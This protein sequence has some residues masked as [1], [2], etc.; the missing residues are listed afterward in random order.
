M[1]AGLTFIDTAE[2]YGY[3]MSETFLG[4]A[5]VMPCCCPACPA[6][7][8]CAVIYPAVLPLCC[9]LPCCTVLCCALLRPP[10]LLLA[11]CALLCILHASLRG[12]VKGGAGRVIRR[13]G[14]GGGEEA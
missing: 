6:A 7:C 3:G 13:G 1:A 4:E 10:A 14:E 12:R 5:A 2:V 9:T 8:H 11:C